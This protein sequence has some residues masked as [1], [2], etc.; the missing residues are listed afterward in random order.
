MF[1]R[2]CEQNNTL[3]DLCNSRVVLVLSFIC[4]NVDYSAGRN[5][6]KIY[7]KNPPVYLILCVSQKR[8][9]KMLTFTS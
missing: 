5:L 3:F 7:I 2:I 9:D 1:Q 4:I 6:Y 8:D